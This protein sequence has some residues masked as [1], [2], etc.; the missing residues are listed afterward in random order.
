MA[1]AYWLSKFQLA[2]EAD[3]VNALRPLS[4]LI[5]ADPSRAA[6]QSFTRVVGKNGAGH[7]LRVGFPTCAWV[8]DWLPQVDI[9]ILRGYEAQDVLIRT[10]TDEG[11]TRAF[12]IFACYAQPLIFGDIDAR[13]AFAERDDGIRQRR[14]VTLEFFGLV[15]YVP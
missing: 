5:L 10:E 14:G 9:D 13:V 6:Y 12:K 7:T 3:G 1:T 11:A 2:L 4:E 8:W 15:E